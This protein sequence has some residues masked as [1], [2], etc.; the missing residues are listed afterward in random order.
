MLTSTVIGLLTRLISSTLPCD[1]MSPA[2]HGYLP[3]A[4][5]QGGQ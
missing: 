3:L 2:G 4:Q 1:L 5:G